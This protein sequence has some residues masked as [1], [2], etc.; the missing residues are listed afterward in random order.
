MRVAVLGAERVDDVHARV[1]DRSVEPPGQV[2]LPCRRLADLVQVS[3]PGTISAAAWCA[4]QHRGSRHGHEPLV[5]DLGT[6]GFAAA[7]GAA[8]EPDERLLHLGDLLLYVLEQRQVVFALEGLGARD[9][10]GAG[11]S[12]RY[13]P[14]P[15]PHSLTRAPGRQVRPAR[16]RGGRPRRAA[17]AGPSTA[18][19]AEAVRRP[20]RSGRSGRRTAGR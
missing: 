14:R 2:G 7:V 9:R 17:A 4:R 15:W 1:L 11:R 3:R 20:G 12:W 13:P 6:A 16:L 18:R 5:G 10:P 19:P 8:V